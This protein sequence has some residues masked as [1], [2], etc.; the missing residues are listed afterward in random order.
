[1]VQ[2]NP[3]LVYHNNQKKQIKFGTNERTDTSLMGP[4]DSILKAE[5]MNQNSDLRVRRVFAMAPR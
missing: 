4:T 3:Q 2:T 1:M 5:F